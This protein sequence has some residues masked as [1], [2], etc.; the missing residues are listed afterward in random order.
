MVSANTGTGLKIF[1]T[2]SMVTTA[3]GSYQLW[4]SLPAAT[5]HDP[6]RTRTTPVS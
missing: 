5:T 3:S 6:K 1:E 4:P 2:P